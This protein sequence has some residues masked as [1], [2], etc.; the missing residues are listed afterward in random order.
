MHFRYFK[1]ELV[2]KG[3]I[4]VQALPQY[5]DAWVQKGSDQCIYTAAQLKRFKAPHLEAGCWYLECA[6]G[7]AIDSEAE[8]KALLDGGAPLVGDVEE[9]VQVL[10]DDE[11]QSSAPPQHTKR[12]R[13]T[14]AALAAERANAS[15]PEPTQPQ[16]SEQTQTE[17]TAQGPEGDLVSPFRVPPLPCPSTSTVPSTVSALETSKNLIQQR[18]AKQVHATSSS[19]GPTQSVEVYLCNA[20]VDVLMSAAAKSTS[21]IGPDPRWVQMHDFL[22]KVISSYRFNFHSSLS[23]NH[24]KYL[25]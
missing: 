2:S 22:R 17:S 13:R 19:S 11:D 10:E 9:S 20:S 6:R 4:D 14:R 15:E 21:L 18:K 3:A 24:G 8:V 12:G 1:R 25:Y 16:P 5:F 7:F 23:N